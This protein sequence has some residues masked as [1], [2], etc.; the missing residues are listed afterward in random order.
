ML[1]AKQKS[2]AIRWC[3]VDTARHVEQIRSGEY[4]DMHAHT[5]FT[6][7]LADSVEAFIAEYKA[8]GAAKLAAMSLDDLLDI[9]SQA[10]ELRFIE[11]FNR[12]TGET[13]PELVVNCQVNEGTARA[14]IH[15]RVA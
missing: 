14:E 13:Y 2:E 15:R 5:T 1:T 3:Y 7:G 6:P 4:F 12:K 11:D 8:E 9:V 10:G